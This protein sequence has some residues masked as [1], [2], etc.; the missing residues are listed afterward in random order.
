MKTTINGVDI[1]DNGNGY[2]TD[3]Y[4]SIVDAVVNHGNILDGLFS[5]NGSIP[6][7]QSDYSTGYR[8]AKDGFIIQ[9]GYASKLTMN[10]NKDQLIGTIVF[11]I[12]FPHVCLKVFGNDTGIN[13]SSAGM[14]FGFYNFTNKGCT[15]CTAL[16]LGIA[17]RV[18]APN[19]FAIGF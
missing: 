15:W 5:T 4:G 17:G 18:Y 8:I 19:W 12:Q 2:S 9:W 3:K 1:P 10:S 14:S 16:G 13:N 7:T 6:N 11:P